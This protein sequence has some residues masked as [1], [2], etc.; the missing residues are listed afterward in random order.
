[1]KEKITMD[2]RPLFSIIIPTFNRASLIEKSLNSVLEQIYY[3]LELIIVDDGSTDNTSEIVK[4]YLLDSRVSYYKIKN[5]ERG[6]ARNFGVQQSTGSYTTFLD[7]DDI[8]LPWH[9]AT[10]YEKIQQ[11][12]CPPAFHL[13]YEMLH[14]N[15]QIDALP[16]LPS[17]VNDKLLEGN[18]FSCMGVFLRHDIALEN[19]FDEDRQLSGSEDYELWMRIAARVPILAFPEVTSRLINHDDRSVIT[20][21][22]EKLMTRIYVLDKKLHAD[23]KFMETFGDRVTMFTSYRSLYLALHLALCGERWLAFKSL[24]FTARQYPYVIFTHRFMVAIKKIVLW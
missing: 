8:L 16:R 14:R 9:L 13:G 18:F 2:E 7:S 6:A 24:L 21:N 4:P 11:E 17:P 10:A 12:N 19:S 22:T 5:S 23:K 3:N 1:V 20:T 15:G